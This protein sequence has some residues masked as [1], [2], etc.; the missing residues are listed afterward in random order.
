MKKE[1]ADKIIV[2]RG[3]AESRQKAQALIMAGLVSSDGQRI[4]KPGQMIGIDQEISLKEK[5]PYVSRGGLKLEEALE[6]FNISIKGKVAA[7]LGAST[8]GFIDCLLQKGAKKIYAVDVD[9]RQID[10]RLREDPRVICKQKNARYL[11]KDDFG[12]SLDII[13]TDLSFISVLK[14]LPAVKEFLGDGVLLSLI[15]PQFEVG[16]GQVGK[17]GVVRNSALHEDVLGK[18]IEEAH[19]ME[20]ALRGLIR[21]SYLGQKGNR[22]FFV[23]WSLEEEAL[24]QGEVQRLIK[25][26][27]WNEKS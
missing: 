9:I 24:S 15:K 25:E 20:F 11:T 2:G 8:G 16:K 17:K 26:A 21:C 19:K 23:F 13:T 12:D 27:V 18:I 6:A 14:V 7:D 10:W 22:E 3:L 4:E 5:M 1:R